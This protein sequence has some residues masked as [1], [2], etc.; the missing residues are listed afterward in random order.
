MKKNR[1]FMALAGMVLAATLTQ[2]C[3]KSF[4]EAQPKGSHFESNYYKNETEA[5]NGLIAVYDVLG[6]KTS[7]YTSKLVVANVASDDHLAGGGGSSDLLHFQVVSNFTLT[8]AMGAHDGLWNGF[9]AGVSRANILIDKLPQANMSEQTKARF[10]AEARFLRAYFYFD[11]VRVFKNVPL[12][13]KPLGS[14]EIENVEQ[15]SP[16]DVYAFITKELQESL[17]D[18]PASVPKVSEAGRITK[19]AGYALLG[20]MLLYQEKFQEAAAALA[21]VNGTPGQDSP[22]GNALLP[23]YNDLWVVANKHNKESILEINH[24]NTSGGSWDCIPCT[25]GNLLNI[26]SSPRSY[27][28]TKKGEAP[29]YIS[30][31][32]FFIVTKQLAQFMKNDYRYA[33]TV[34][35]LDSLADA[36]KVTYEES[37]QNTGY[38]LKK[39]MGKEEDRYS[40]AGDP[41]LNFPQNTY[42]IRL[43][44]T[45]LLEAEALVRGGGSQSRAQAL[46]DAVR[47]R[48]KMTKKPVSLNNIIDERRLELAGEGHRFFDLVRWKLADQYL[49]FKGFKANKNE[50]FPIPLLELNNTKLKQNIEYSGGQ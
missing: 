38:F 28:I 21:Q 41:N 11:L 27:V 16:E 32:G 14:T 19:A 34:E 6:W 15:A 8:P 40:G 5:F 12:I 44:D 31:W 43:A 22:F 17:N 3:S 35:N 39:F 37:Y 4:L 50:I 48:A 30:G 2:S 9:F 47:S 42:E 46:Y 25:E 20:K 1:I 10:N 23:E 24:T 49:S 36:K 26:L 29:T 18:L 45:Y 13:T 33:A 7:N